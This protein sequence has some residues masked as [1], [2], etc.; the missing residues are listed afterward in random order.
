MCFSLFIL[1]PSLGVAVCSDKTSGSGG[2]QCYKE[3]PR[4]YGK[5]ENNPKQVNNVHNN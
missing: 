2:K 3:A 1:I 5:N 4:E